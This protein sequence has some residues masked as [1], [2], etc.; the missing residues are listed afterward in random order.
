VLW[1]TVARG[2]RE[3]EEARFYAV[4]EDEK[5]P[6]EIG[7]RPLL[8]DKGAGPDAMDERAEARGQPGRRPWRRSSC[9]GCVGR[10]GVALG[11]GRGGIPLGEGAPAPPCAM[12]RPSPERWGSGSSMRAMDRDLAEVDPGRGAK[13]GR[14]GVGR[15]ELILG[16]PAPVELGHGGFCPCA[17]EAREEGAMGGSAHVQETER[18]RRSCRWR[19]GGKGKN[20]IMQGREAHIYR[21]EI[22]VGFGVA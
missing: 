7:A 14:L 4:G 13:L 17:R 21:G 8:E 15:K 19:L 22:R 9:A 1:R 2:N 11:N 20:F 16:L 18:R 10:R 6:V 3:R 5:R 12:A